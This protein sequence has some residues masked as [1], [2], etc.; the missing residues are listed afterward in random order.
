M[1][2]IRKNRD[3]LRNILTE[4]YRQ[5]KAVPVDDHWQDEVLRRA[6]LI[7]RSASKR[8]RENERL[9]HPPVRRLV[10]AAGLVTA[11]L[12]LITVAFMRGSGN[13]PDLIAMSDPLEVVVA[14]LFWP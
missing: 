3:T 11:I 8:T 9:L 4:A 6:R 5:K 14:Q 2:L 13:E 12:L 7:S 1:R 10:P